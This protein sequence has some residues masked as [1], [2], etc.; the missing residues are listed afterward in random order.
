MT[1]FGHKGHEEEVLDPLK[2]L[3]TRIESGSI[4][5]VNAAQ[6]I[7]GLLGRFSS[8][9]QVRLINSVDGISEPARGKLKG[10]LMLA[11]MFASGVTAEQV[12]DWNNQSNRDRTSRET[13]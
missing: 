10:A 3:A 11:G 5:P 6:E 13:N 7:S 4:Q 1:E 9:E 12:K 2:K 8:Q